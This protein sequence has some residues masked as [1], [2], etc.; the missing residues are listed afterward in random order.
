MEVTLHCRARDLFKGR[1]NVI[2]RVSFVAGR[3]S[4][5]NA[6]SVNKTGSRRRG[7]NCNPS[8]TSFG[9]TQLQRNPLQRDPNDDAAGMGTR[10]RDEE[11]AL[12][13]EIWCSIIIATDRRAG[14]S[15]LPCDIVT[16]SYISI[17]ASRPPRLPSIS[18]Y[19]SQRLSIALI[20]N[21]P[22]HS[23]SITDS[24]TRCGNFA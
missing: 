12:Y 3:N 20:G 15:F 1:I 18:I 14:C 23:F 24:T 5:C 4:R 17:T 11:K 16:K 10:L 2:F 21:L 6:D 8:D 22:T 13:D 7:I 19:P 9:R